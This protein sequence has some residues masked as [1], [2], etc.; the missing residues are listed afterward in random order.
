[1]LTNG[2]STSE[3]YSAAAEQGEI[4]TGRDDT[5]SERAVGALVLPAAAEA[6]CRSSS[7]GGPDDP[8]PADCK[9]CDPC[10]SSDSLSHPEATLTTILRVVVALGNVVPWVRVACLAS[11]DLADAAVAGELVVNPFT[12]TKGA[13]AL[14][15]AR[16][17][18]ATG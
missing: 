15:C 14:S 2:T 16:A 9:A 6:G 7:S 10:A 5:A 4:T 18:L 1:M 12:A 8:P 11:V 17:V 13:K 3:P